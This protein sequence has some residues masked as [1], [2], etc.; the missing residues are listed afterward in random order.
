[1]AMGLLPHTAAIYAAGLLAYNLFQ[2]FSYTAFTALELE[3]VGPRNA[4]SGTMMAMLTA[5]SNVPISGMTW[6]DSRMHDLRGLSAMLYTDAAASVATA[7]LLLAVALP[8]FDR[9]L[10][11]RL[12]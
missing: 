8:L 10:R 3:I 2:G 6:V 12:A 9:H 11:K 1:M 4:L 7:V 5:S